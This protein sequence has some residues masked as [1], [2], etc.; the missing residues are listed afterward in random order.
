MRSGQQPNWG[1]P[2][3][4]LLLMIWMPRLQTTGPRLVWSMEKSID[5]QHLPGNRWL[6]RGWPSIWREKRLHCPSQRLLC[7]ALQWY[8]AKCSLTLERFLPP[9]N[10]SFILQGS[11]R[12]ALFI[13]NN[14]D[15][16]NKRIIKYH[17]NRQ[18]K[19]NN[20]PGDLTETIQV[21]KVKNR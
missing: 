1:C 8:G 16:A 2:K 14:T 5:D 18:I 3:G 20:V 10:V 9:G 11:D 12:V 13:S 19:P 15:P 4:I 6:H 7:W 17:R 21:E